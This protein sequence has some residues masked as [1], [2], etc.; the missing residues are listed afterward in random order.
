MNY[1]IIKNLLT[2]VTVITTLVT[3]V[4]SNAS[5]TEMCGNSTTTGNALTLGQKECTTGNG[6]Y[7]WVDIENDGT[8]L[9][10]STFGGT[11]QADILTS[12]AGWAT[13]SRNDN[14][15]NNPGT[16]EQLDL[17]ADEGRLYISLFGKHE[18]VSFKVQDT[19]INDGMCGAKTLSGNA[20][21]LDQQECISGN[22]LYYHLEVEQ[23]NTNIT[24]TTSGGTGDADIYINQ[25]KW[26][27]RSRYTE[28][29]ENEGTENSLIVNADSGR[30]Y[31]SIFGKNQGVSLLVSAIS[32][33]DSD[34][35]VVIDK[36][37]PVNIPLP[38]LNS[39]SEFTDTVNQIIASSWSDWSAISSGS[40]DPITDVANAIHFLAEQDDINSIDLDQLMYFLKNYSFNGPYQDFTRDEAQRLSNALQAVAK[41]SEFH[42]TNAPVG[43]IQESYATAMLNFTNSPISEYF[44]EQ[45]PHLLAL[46]QV[47]SEL[48]EPYTH[49]N[50][51]ASTNQLLK[52]V[53]DMAYYAD[54]SSALHSAFN[55]NML[56]VISVLRSYGLGE[57]GLDLRWDDDKDK[58]WILGHLFIALGNVS[59]IAD[60]ATQARIDSIIIEIFDKVTN[61]ISVDTAKK[62]VTATFLETTNRLCDENDA[63]AQY[64]IAKPTVDDILSINYQCNDNILIRSQAMTNDQFVNACNKMTAIEDKFHAFFATNNIPVADDNNQKLEVV[65]YASPED[66][67]EYGYEF[68]NH[69]TDNG[70]IYLEG[71]PSVVG[72]VARFHAMECPDAWVPYSC[73]AGGDVYNLEHEFVHYLDARYNLYG[74]YSY[75]DNTVSWAEGWAEFISKDVG[76][77]RNLNSVVGEFI[78]PLD[79][80]L[81]ME[82]GFSNLYPWSYLAMQY[83]SQERSADVALLVEALRKTDKSLYQTELARISATDGDGFLNW[84]QN[85]TDAVAPPQQIIPAANTFGSCDLVY[86]YVRDSSVSATVSITNSTDTPVT[87]YWVDSS[88]GEVDFDYPYKTLNNGENYTADNWKKGD[89]L[90]VADQVRNC[91]GV[92]VMTETVNTYTIN[93]TMVAD[94]ITSEIIPAANTLGS[95]DLLN[96][97]ERTTGDAAISITNTTNNTV[98]LY[99]VNPSI[100]KADLTKNYQTLEK[101]DSYNAITWTQ[102]DRMMIADSEDSCVAVAVLTETTNNY[103][104]DASL[105]DID[106][107]SE[108]LTGA[109]VYLSLDGTALVNQLASNDSQTVSPLFQV[110]GTDAA[111]LFSEENVTS[112]AKAI[113]ERALSYSGEDT[114]GLE[115]MMYYLRAAY[116]V[117]YYSPEDIAEYSSAA[118]DNIINALNVFFN[119]DN[120]WLVSDENAPVLREAITLID[121]ANLGSKFNHIILKV[122]AEYNEQ[123]KNNRGMNG[124]AN[125]I[126]TILFRAQWDDEMQAI[127]AYDDSILDA[128]N[129]FQ[130]IHRD[131][132]DTD[133]EYVLVN[134]VRELGRLYHIEEMIPR[135]KVLVKGVIDSTNKDDNTKVIWLAAASM[136][137]YYDRADCGYYDMCGFAYMLEKDTLSFNYKCS[138]SLKIRAQELY[139]DQGEWICGVL[140]QQEANFHLILET[141]EIPV[142]DDNNTSLEL[143]VFDSS[144]EYGT[145][146]GQFFNIDTN[147]GGMY[148]E[149][150]PS[151]DKNQARFIAYEAEWKRPDFHVWNLQHEYV[152][153]LD[154][155]FNLYGSFSAGLSTDTVWWTE[156]LA[157]YISN[158][159]DNTRAIDLGK[160]QEYALSEIFK[161]DYSVGQDRIYRW[162]YLAVRFMFENHLDDVN[163]ILAYLRNNQYQDYQVFIDNI[164]TSY[165]AEWNLWLVSDLSTQ[166][167]GIVEFGPNDDEALSSGQ[168]GNWEGEP[169]TIST[170]FSPCVVENPENAYDKEMRHIAFDSTVECI[171]SESGRA[172][173]SIPNPDGLASSLLITTS[174]G[175]GNADIL[176]KID[177]RPSAEDNDGMAN[178]NGNNDSITVELSADVYWH[179]ITLTGDFGGMK[180]QLSVQ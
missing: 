91:L 26:A 106:D 48:S 54:N 43:L 150:S 137:D 37:V 4:N 120:A 114:T 11:G 84:A 178:G 67:D 110:V 146:A 81:F 95:C 77:E 51:G 3:S 157:E 69:S 7:F 101:G 131:I 169:V 104:V 111:Q 64:C 60:E 126:F 20:L 99:W 68:F 130:L 159:D 105:F 75:H 6:L 122:L 147:N 25:G 140:G 30:L 90:V 15:T 52:A 96:W 56:K 121:S 19:S 62:E 127:F 93:Q 85:N 108:P 128:L 73:A 2:A 59:N 115:S 82:Y 149:G 34:D 9:Q 180:L 41:M 118:Q 133:A 18:Q 168:A 8:P 109:D 58:K 5:E 42:S 10:I 55:D 44:A 179:Y 176:Y 70:G 135:V 31:V 21:T 152:H 29:S 98:K 87:L 112:V 116:Y 24:I 102:G 35:Y 141:L 79:N 144:D 72:N 123:W 151:N 40:I 153:Y 162:G 39:I 166:R 66:Y 136:A 143:V 167:S 86:Q 100:G 138:D 129:N 22:G 125:A 139:N 92:A 124:A 71:D 78:P 32:S 46:L 89:R 12:T 63:L 163:Q 47:Y 88:T 132:L 156:G 134:A 119:N 16:V 172:S 154:A 1:Q 165:D 174:G 107:N 155:R 158:L 170:D 23:D 175:W 80:I 117:Q 65:V 13:G 164:A 14:R 113:E 45:L 160:N 76:N 145:Y 36:D 50:Y 142:A 161:N 177:G 74:K 173:F 103:T 27:T 171:T 49:A 148:L 94:A 17:V 61:D 33:S 57:T 38:E 83:L 28:F 53:Y 97:H